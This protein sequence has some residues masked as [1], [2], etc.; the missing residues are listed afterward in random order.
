[1]TIEAE[2]GV[3][4]VSDLDPLFCGVQTSLIPRSSQR[5]GLGDAVLESVL[6]LVQ[7]RQGRQQDLLTMWIR[8]WVS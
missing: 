1:M 2:K 3:S 6:T 4:A 8:K 5:K 7:P